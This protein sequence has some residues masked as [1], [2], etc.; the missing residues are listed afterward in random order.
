MEPF[1]RDARDRFIGDMLARLAEPDV[2]ERWALDPKLRGRPADLRS[3]VE[4]LISQAA[5]MQFVGRN[6]I[7]AFIL[8]AAVA[9]PA[10]REQSSWGWIVAL[11]R[12]SE[13]PAVGRMRLIAAFLPEPE[14]H[15]CFPS[16]AAA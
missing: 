13:K 7:R 15:I 11:L 1:E 16:L 6:D 2:Q 12:A 3:E 4:R 10:L 9:G 5:A 14:R 8:L